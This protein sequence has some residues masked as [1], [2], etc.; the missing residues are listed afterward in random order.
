WLA[1]ERHQVPI[2][3]LKLKVSLLPQSASA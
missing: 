3:N 2:R 1:Q